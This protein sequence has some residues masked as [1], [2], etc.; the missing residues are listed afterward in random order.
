M[1]S[2]CYSLKIWIRDVSNPQN[3]IFLIY[4]QFLVHITPNEIKKYLN[5]THII[6]FNTY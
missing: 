4:I 3:I 2:L 6:Q 1:P 5:L